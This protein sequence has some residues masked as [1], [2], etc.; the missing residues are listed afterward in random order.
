MGDRTFTDSAGVVWHVWEV[1]PGIVERRS[2]GD[3]RRT[4][5]PDPVIERRG[6]LERRVRARPRGVLRPEF[7]R[8]WLC[9]DAGMFRRRLA[10][11]PTGWEDCSDAELEALCGRAERGGALRSA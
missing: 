1:H 2:G 7:E 6:H 3:R 4:A 11:V 8:G 9:F 10:P 5:A